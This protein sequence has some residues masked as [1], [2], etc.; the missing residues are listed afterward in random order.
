[1]SEEL[2]RLRAVSSLPCIGR[3]AVTFYRRSRE[4]LP[5]GKRRP[6]FPPGTSS[7]AAVTA[8]LSAAAIGLTYFHSGVA[9]HGRRR[10]YPRPVHSFTQAVML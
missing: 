5:F 3:L 2:F 8:L 7:I 4:P 1:M 6:L 9:N 10:S